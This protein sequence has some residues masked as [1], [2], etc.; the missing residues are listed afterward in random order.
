MMFPHSSI[1]G[2]KTGIRLLAAKNSVDGS[3]ETNA[4]SLPSASCQGRYARQLLFFQFKYRR[5][6][7]LFTEKSMQTV[8]APK[9]LAYH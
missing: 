2:Q 8:L 5:C 3:T 1:A 7:N 9:K 6:D 4:I